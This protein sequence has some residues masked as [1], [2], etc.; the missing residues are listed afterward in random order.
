MIVVDP[1]RYASPSLTLAQISNGFGCAV[2]P[3]RTLRACRASPATMRREPR[4]VGLD[5]YLNFKSS[6]YRRG[7][8]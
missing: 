7:N 2:G 5:R 1:G 3:S 6:R 4:E 8:I